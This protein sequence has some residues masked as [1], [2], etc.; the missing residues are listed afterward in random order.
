MKYWDQK[1][2]GCEPRI[3]NLT[4]DFQTQDKSSILKSDCNKGVAL[5]DLE[6]S[7]F[8]GRVVC[9]KGGGK[10][11]GTKLLYISQGYHFFI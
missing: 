6:I 7:L 10:D 4:I 11:G 1:I 2:M 9:T 5:E 3:M 8:N